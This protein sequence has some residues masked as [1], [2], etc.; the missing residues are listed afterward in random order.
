MQKLISW[1]IALLLAVLCSSSAEPG[2]VSLEEACPDVLLDIRYYSTFN[3]VGRRIPG[4]EK[5]VAYLTR[6]A[7][8]QLKAANAELM[9]QGYRLKVHDAYRPKRAV[10]FFVRWARDLDDQTMKGY[11]YPNCPKSEL[12]IRG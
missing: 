12:F 6:E 8:E 5:P 1:T 4:Y 11:F 3:F 10:E 7:A 9:K 2:F